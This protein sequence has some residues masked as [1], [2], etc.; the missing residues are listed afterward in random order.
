MEGLISLAA[1]DVIKIYDNGVDGSGYGWVDKLVL[2]LKRQ[3]QTGSA[4]NFN[5]LC[6]SRWNAV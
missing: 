6:I 4:G 5:T 2:T 1:G 3:N